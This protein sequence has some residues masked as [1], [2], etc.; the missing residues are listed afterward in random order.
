MFGLTFPQPGA[1]PNATFSEKLQ[2]ETSA[3]MCLGQMRH[4][5]SKFIEQII[6]MIHILFGSSRH[7]IFHLN[8]AIYNL[9][10]HSGS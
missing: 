5:I 6:F 3:Q 10:L 8:V 9:E 4:P 7:P 2:N 1:R